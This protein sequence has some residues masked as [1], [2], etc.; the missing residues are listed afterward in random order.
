MANVQRTLRQWSLTLVSLA[1]LAAG[2]A[3]S[4]TPVADKVRECNRLFSASR[5]FQESGDLKRALAAAEE[6]LQL[7]R[8][9]WPA[10][11]IELTGYLNRVAEVQ[12]ALGDFPAARSVRLESL[13]VTEKTRG[14]D[15]WQTFDAR[16]AVRDVDAWSKL[17]PEQRRR[18]AEADR[19]ERQIGGHVR[20]KE[21][22]QAIELHE[23]VLA[24]RR[25]CLGE[26][27]P[28]C[29]QHLNYLG[30]LHGNLG[31]WKRSEECYQQA[32]K[33][34]LQAGESPHPD[35]A[36]VLNNLGFVRNV[37][38]DDEGSA[39]YYRRALTMRRALGADQTATLR[40][41][42]DVL[43]RLGSTQTA[44]G[45]VAAARKTL[46]ERVALLT[47]DKGT[48]PWK[49]ANARVALDTAARRERF[50]EEIGRAHV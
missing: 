14:K 16:Q 10:G 24:I 41:L 26:A 13:A 11:A 47:T 31:D 39:S 50:N 38:K 19:L 48:S 23:Q 25:E 34:R 36:Q 12:H 28:L 20:K 7:A 8:A 9:T 3:R 22:P 15:H 49:L 17:K 6:S 33:I 29:A 35:T 45:D 1:V 5:E 18:L 2:G 4:Q 30:V 40:A 27:H 42:T 32:L 46:G 21:Y 43:D 44:R 37:Q